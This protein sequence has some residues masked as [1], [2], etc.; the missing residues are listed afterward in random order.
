MNFG[1]TTKY[2]SY[3]SEG[4]ESKLYTTENA[5]K[6]ESEINGKK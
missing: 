3:R 6:K 1:N 4:Y 5:K 2:K